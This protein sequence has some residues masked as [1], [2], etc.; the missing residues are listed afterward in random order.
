VA[1]NRPHLNII[2]N[3]GLS[4]LDDAEE[5]LKETAGVML[6]RALYEQ[7]FLLSQVDEKFFGQ[8]AAPIRRSDVAR[9]VARHFEALDIPVWR[10]ARHMLGLFHG[11]PGARHWRREISQNARSNLA[12]A[13]WLT[14]LAQSVD[15]NPSKESSL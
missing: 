11:C 8:G 7:P 10:Y 1:K 4:S 13:A 5:Q 6:G 15:R 14:D 3:G 2:L 12:S 9:H